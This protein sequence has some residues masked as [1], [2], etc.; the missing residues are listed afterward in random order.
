[1][2]RRPDAGKPD[3][4]AR[5]PSRACGTRLTPDRPEE[6]GRPLEVCAGRTWLGRA[7]AQPAARSLQRSAGR[8]F[9]QGHERESCWLSA[10][11]GGRP[12]SRGVTVRFR[13]PDE[14]SA[15]PDGRGS[16]S[17]PAGQGLNRPRRGKIEQATGGTPDRAG[18]MRSRA[19]DDEVSGARRCCR[20][21]RLMDRGFGRSNKPQAGCPTV[22]GA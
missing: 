13:R 2:R 22:P 6:A 17:L 1:M 4:A 7:R 8:D 20:G 14:G 15:V 3:R 9:Q 21:G 11:A 10:R 19:L 12:T 18:R 16:S 5:G